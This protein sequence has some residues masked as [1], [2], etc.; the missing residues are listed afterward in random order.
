[1]KKIF[2][3]ALALVMVLSMA[4]A[5]ASPCTG[6][7]DWTKAA[8]ATKCGQGKVEVVPFVK[9]N[10]ACGGYDWE[11]SSCAGAVASEN[12]YWAVKLTVDANA[13]MEWWNEAVLTVAAKETNYAGAKWDFSKKAGK[14]GIDFEEDETVVYYAL[15]AGGWI[16]VE[17][18]DL[19]LKD[20][21]FSAKVNKNAKASK[22]KVCATLSS[23]G[24]DFRKGVVGDYFVEYVPAGKG[25]AAVPGE[26][27][28]QVPTAAWLKD[29]KLISNDELLV[30]NTKGNDDKLTALKA[31]GK[32]EN[33]KLATEAN[34]VTIANKVAALIAEYTVTYVVGGTEAVAGA[35]AYLLISE[36][37]DGKAGDPLVQYVI[38]DGKVFDIYTWDVCG[39]ATYADVE[40]FFGIKIGTK[41]DQKLVNNNF[42]WDFEQEFCLPWS[43]NAS[44]IVDTECV[45]AIPK[46]GDASVLAWLF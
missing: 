21:V 8:A 30:F 22:V 11:I 29:N 42:G 46:T 28:T 5:F 17:D 15:V 12:I 27:V 20:V 9:V 40:A 36:N 34:Y 4:S 19:D 10:N 14:T 35:P 1:M 16:D 23:L 6:G 39:A 3:I 25:T 38:F 13:D 24:E 41:V 7:F 26:E 45:V 37:D 33:S 44:S 18:E 31:S 2:A 43:A 32:L